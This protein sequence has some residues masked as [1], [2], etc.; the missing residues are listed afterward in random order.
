MLPFFGHHYSGHYRPLHQPLQ[1]IPNFPSNCI[2]LTITTITRAL[3]QI[4]DFSSKTITKHYTPLHKII[5]IYGSESDHYSGHY[6]ALHRR[7][8]RLYYY[9][10]C[11]I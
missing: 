6:R 7:Y 11:N 1:Q 2:T 4:F 3:Q 5:G 10:H 9:F 8:I